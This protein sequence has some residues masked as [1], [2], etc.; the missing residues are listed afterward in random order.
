MGDS[1]MMQFSRRNFLKAGS[2][3]GLA[4]TVPLT[5]CA[6]LQGLGKAKPRAG[7]QLYSVRGICKPEKVPEIFKALK[8]MGY[9]GVEFAGYYGKSAKELR[10]ILDD[11]GLVACGTHTGRDSINPD[12]IQQTIEFAQEIGNKYL[13][14]PGM[15]GKTKEEWIAHAKAFSTA[16]ATLKPLGMYVG[17]HNHQQEFKEKFD[18][19]TC[20][21]ETLFANASP[22]VCS[23]MDIGHCVSAGEDPV[24]WFKKFPNR[25][26]SVHVKEVYGGGYDGILGHFPEGGKHVDWDQVF[27]TLEADVT[28]WYVVESEAHADRLDDVKGCIDFLK[29]KGRA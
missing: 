2:A 11:T 23:Q 18:D 14:V 10:Q 25:A 12:K 20:K 9:A 19:G 7:V 4:L 1:I 13:M 22:D 16:A 5:G 21:W 29:S 27:P 3:A 15:G 6:A 24:A 28:Q 8:E 26:V 17:Y